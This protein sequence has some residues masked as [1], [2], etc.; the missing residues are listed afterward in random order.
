MAA[1]H[2][3]AESVT[4]S[5]PREAVTAVINKMKEDGKVVNEVDSANV[6][7]HSPELEPCR[8]A[9]KKAVNKVIKHKFMNIIAN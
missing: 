9:F 7:F 8:A 3:G 6:A 2:N 4:I 1:C 5:G